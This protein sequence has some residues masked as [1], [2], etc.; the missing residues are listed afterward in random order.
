MTDYIFDLN[1]FDK[2]INKLEILTKQDF[3]NAMLKSFNV[4]KF[5]YYL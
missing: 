5:N 3:V 1:K 4:N 2:L